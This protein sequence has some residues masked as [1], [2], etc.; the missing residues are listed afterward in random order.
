[1]RWYLGAVF[2]LIV[3]LVFQLGLLAYA[4]Y[5]LL[6]IMVVSRFVARHW[7][8]NLAA[9]R[10]CNC[11]AA[12]IGD[13]AA[14]VVT[15]RNRGRLPVAW[16]L[17]EDSLPRQALVQRPP[18]VK[19]HNRRLMIGMI[20]RGGEKKMLYQVEFLMR[21]Y[22]QLG[23]VVLETGDLFGLHR[24]Y[25]VATEP[26]FVLVY[27]RLVP[28]AG[29]DLASRRPV[30]EI[31]LTHRL[32]EDPTRI[33][34]VRQY[35]EGDPL[36]RVNWR[37][38]ARTGLLHSKIYEPSTIAGATVMLAF[39]RD[40]YPQANEPL[41]SELAVTTAASIANEVYLMGQQIGLVTNGRD[42]VD[43]IRQE[44]WAHDYRTREA[45]Q[46]NVNM[47]DKSDRLRPVIVP[48]RRGPEQLWRIL[49]T[50]ARVELTD[51]LSFD[52]LVT[53]TVS[54]LPRDATV[55]AVM[56]KVT[57]EAALAL[58]SLRRRGYAVVGVLIIFEQFEYEEH[59]GRLLAQGVDARRVTDEASLS[60]LCGQH[61]LR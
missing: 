20:R 17:V 49:E 57:P 19:V 52:Q 48:T 27:P 24:R 7:I 26:H 5:V 12:E 56:S 8:D 35:Q 55:I 54:R 1:M 16:T 36:N 14:V 21:G 32:Y 60:A 42:A 51:G 44:G 58:G 3:A 59:A 61:L 38:T 45:A 37:A 10:E 13:K 30:G 43:R 46:K 25:R 40:D 2:I 15:V 47:V 31:R 34:G 28:L 11:D 39:H 41:R 50:L 29:Y 53:E 6:G 23:P 4:M 33:A 9:T 18:R 22:Y